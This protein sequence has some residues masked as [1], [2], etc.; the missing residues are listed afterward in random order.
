MSHHKRALKRRKM[1]GHGR[2]EMP[3]GKYL[4]LKEVGAGVEDVWLGRVLYQGH[5]AGESQRH[6]T[7]RQCHS[8]DS[9]KPCGHSLLWRATRMRLPP[10]APTRERRRE[11]SRPT[12]KA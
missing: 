11:G 4:R 2:R 10:A 5:I 1:L 12:L 8:V 7:Q 6:C 3:G 9:F